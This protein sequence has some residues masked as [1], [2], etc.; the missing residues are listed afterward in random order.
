[1]ASNADIEVRWIEAWNDVCAIVKDRRDVR[2]Q[3][4]DWAV[5][6]VEECLAW[7]QESVYAGYL[8]RVEEGWVG[9]V[10]GVI[11]RRW[12]PEDEAGPVTTADRPRE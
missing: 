7:L 2:C 1:M 10:R 12:R 8:V 5:V 4:P 3:L 11:A 9:H 6:G